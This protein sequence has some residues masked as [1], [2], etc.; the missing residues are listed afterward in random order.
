[1]LIV[2]HGIGE[3]WVDPGGEVFT[4][5]SAD[6]LEQPAAS[7]HPIDRMRKRKKN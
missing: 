6:V 7:I 5:C 3:G 2:D 1:M 4:G